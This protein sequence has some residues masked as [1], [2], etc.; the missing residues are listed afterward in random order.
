MKRNKKADRVKFSK[1]VLK[2][3]KENNGKFIGEYGPVQQYELP[4]LFVSVYGQEQHTFEYSV[5]FRFKPLSPNL[6]T[7]SQYPEVFRSD[8]KIGVILEEFDLF[9]NAITKNA[10]RLHSKYLES[11]H[12]EQ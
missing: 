5:N 7:G 11:Q 10:D 6:G 3:I 2:R 9:F 4:G 12:E 8:G 1:H